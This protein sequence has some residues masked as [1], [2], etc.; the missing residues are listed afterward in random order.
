MTEDYVE[1]ASHMML[2]PLSQIRA[3]ALMTSRQSTTETTTTATLDDTRN[4]NGIKQSSDGDHAAIPT[5]F[6]MMP[7]SQ[8]LVHISALGFLKSAMRQ[9]TVIEKWSPYE[10]A[11]FEA[12]IAEYGKNFARIRK[13]IGMTKSVQ[14]VIEFYY[15]WKKTSHYTHWKKE[16]IPEHLDVG[17]DE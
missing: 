10:I 16:Y 11:T 8:Y 14:D 4:T 2:Y 9:P 12:S 6:A 5:N 7:Q 17:V 3:A 15:I 1:L 13:E